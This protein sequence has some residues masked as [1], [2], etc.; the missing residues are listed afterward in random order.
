L[1]L[2]HQAPARGLAEPSF[3]YTN[4]WSRLLDNAA[5]LRLAEGATCLSVLLVRGV[6]VRVR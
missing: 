6:L 2:G 5:A 4:A 1:L 3:E